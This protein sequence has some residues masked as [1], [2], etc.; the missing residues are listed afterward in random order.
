M[1]W[2]TFL[3]PWPKVTVV[4]SITKNLLVRAIKWEPLIESLQNITALLPS[5]G[6]YLIRFWRSSVGNFYFGKFSLK[7]SD[8]FFQ[9][10]TLFWSYLRNGWS[11]WCETKRKFIGWML[12]T[13]CDLW[14]HSWPW[15]W[16]FQGQIFW[17]HPRPWPWSWHFKVKVWNS[18]ISGMGRP[19]DMERKVC[20]SS[21]HDHDID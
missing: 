11:D 16:M 1:Y 2:M 4:A 8:V 6:Y 17:P 3:W 13:I 15:H 18:F 5:H 9:G 7:N 19:I 20:E 12:G 21:I 10:Q 14:P